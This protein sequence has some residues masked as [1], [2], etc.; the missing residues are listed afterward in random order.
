[1]TLKQMPQSNIAY[2]VAALKIRFCTQTLRGSFRLCI[3]KV[4][5]VFLHENG[6]FLEPVTWLMLMLM[7]IFTL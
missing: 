5:F 4:K 6:W 7:Y 3:L 1:M 2:G